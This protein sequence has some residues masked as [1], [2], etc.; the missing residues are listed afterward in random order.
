MGA[1]APLQ[2]MASVVTKCS[3]E[4]EILDLSII[5]EIQVKKCKKSGL[6]IGCKLL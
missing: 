3:K 5:W 1:K 2:T 4:P 6:H